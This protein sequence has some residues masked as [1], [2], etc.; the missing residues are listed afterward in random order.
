MR[1]SRGI[2]KH[3][4]E[5]APDWW[6]PE[7]KGYWSLWKEAIEQRRK[8]EEIIK[9]AIYQ[10]PFLV[11]D[12]GC[13]QGRLLDLAPQTTEMILVDISEKMIQEAKRRAE[14]LDVDNASFIV[15]DVEHIPLRDSLADVTICLQT[16]IHVPNREKAISEIK[17]ITKQNGIIILDIPLHGLREFFYWS[18]RHGGIKNLIFDILRKIGLLKSYSS[19]MDRSKFY[20][21][22]FRLNL[23]IANNFKVG[24]W[25]TFCL[26]R[27]D[28]K[29]YPSRL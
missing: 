7:D 5:R 9:H 14:S 24:P 16:L 29:D 27:C 19:P 15:T 28:D 3:M 6:R 8:I 12:V 18:I 26:K 13:G 20:D 22:L 21:I 1:M 11:V 2:K 4:R 10:R 25:D 17:R 23:H